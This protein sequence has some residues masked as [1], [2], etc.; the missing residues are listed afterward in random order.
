M[1]SILFCLI[2]APVLDTLET[3][4]K[5]V[6]PRAQVLA[7]LDD[8]EIN[9]WTQWSKYAFDVASDLLSSIN[10]LTVPRKIQ[11]HND[12]IKLLGSVLA[13]NEYLSNFLQ[14]KANK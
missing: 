10:I 7:I 14:Q 11:V 12:G 3:R 5:A 4:I 6:D 8:I 1:S 13:N 2:L 9:I